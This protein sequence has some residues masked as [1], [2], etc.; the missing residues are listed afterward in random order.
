MLGS[1]NSKPAYAEA[2]MM[3]QGPKSV[4]F[5]TMSGVYEVSRD[6]VLVAMNEFDLEFRASENDFILRLWLARYSKLPVSA[7]KPRDRLANPGSR[8]DA[9]RIADEM[10]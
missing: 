10:V 6:Q 1:L 7:V 5:K 2:D 3:N 8:A 4:A 9:S